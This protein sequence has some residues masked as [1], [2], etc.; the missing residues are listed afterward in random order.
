M[1]LAHPSGPELRILLV[2]DSPQDAELA[3]RVMERAGVRCAAVRVDTEAAFRRELAQFKPQI[4]FSDF[5]M[6]QFDGLAA[7]GVARHREI[8]ASPLDALAG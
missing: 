8:T 2:E 7:L 4:I 3:L 5:S 1:T 6:P